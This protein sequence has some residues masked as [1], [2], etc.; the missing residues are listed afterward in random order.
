[1]AEAAPPVREGALSPRAEA[2]VKLL[3]DQEAGTRATAAETLGTLGERAAVKPLIGVLTDEDER[4]R[5]AAAK[6]LGKIGDPAAAPALAERVAD[7]Q[8]DRLSINGVE[9]RSKDSAL[10]ALRALGPGEV[11][12]A[13]TR[14]L[15]SSHFRVREWAAPLV[16]GQKGAEAADA[17]AE[18]VGDDVMDKSYVDDGKAL[19]LR[20][21]RELAPDRVLPS[22]TRALVSGEFRVREWAARALAETKDPKAV[23]ALVERVADEK[24]D[25]LRYVENSKDAALAALRALA[26]EKVGD[27][28]IRATAAKDP[29]VRS[30]ATRALAREAEEEAKARSKKAP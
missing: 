22:L 14:A 7:D 16:A 4:V 10:E 21:L 6:A 24:S 9:V 25:D 27:A 11:T 26:P 23:P 15:K 19:A 28:L 8:P 29:Q 2:M 1:M 3:A 17:L 13:L 18:R 5:G 12:R 20:G 30:W